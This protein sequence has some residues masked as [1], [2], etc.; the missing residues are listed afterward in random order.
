MPSAANSPSKGDD[1]PPAASS[2]STRS[3]ALEPREVREVG[4]RRLERAHELGVL[5]R[6]PGQQLVVLGPSADDVD[7]LAGG[8]LPAERHRDER[9]DV[10]RTEG[11]A[12][13][14]A[15]SG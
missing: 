6:G 1:A 13:I 15:T 7:Q 11:T 14:R 3:G 2:A 8:R 10:H 5:V 4:V 12:I 9:G